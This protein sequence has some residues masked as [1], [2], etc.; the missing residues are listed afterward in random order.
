MLATRPACHSSLASCLSLLEESLP[1]I[2]DAYAVAVSDVPRYG[3]HV[4]THDHG[5]SEAPDGSPDSILSSE[6]KPLEKHK[7]P[8]PPSILSPGESSYPP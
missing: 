5:G 4:H 1:S 2:P 6:P 8:P 3:S 7:P